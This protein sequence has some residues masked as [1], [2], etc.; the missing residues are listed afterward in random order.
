MLQ[1]PGLANLLRHFDHGAQGAGDRVRCPVCDRNSERH[2]DQS[3]QQ[4]NKDGPGTGAFISFAAF[5]QNVVSFCISDIQR[6]N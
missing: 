1:V 2:R 6:L 4:G 5:I 3:A